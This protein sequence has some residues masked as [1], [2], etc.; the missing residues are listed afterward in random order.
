MTSPKLGQRTSPVEVAN[1]SAHG[2]WLF[3]GDTE[4]FLPYE[5]FPWFR[6]AKV[7]EIL[8]VELVH[9][10]HLYWPLLDVDLELGSLKD[11]D[12][13]PLVASEADGNA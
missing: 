6:E 4:Y 5:K 7:R 9:G 10:F 12:R 3:V 2:I 13:F 1:I 8:D 11:P